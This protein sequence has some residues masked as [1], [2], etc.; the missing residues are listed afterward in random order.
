MCNAKG[1]PQTTQN[2][3]SNTFTQGQNSGTST[4]TSN[5]V[6][7]NTSNVGPNPE[8][9]ALYQQL[10]GNASGLAQTP[11]NPY[12]GQQVAPFTQA[13][14]DAGNSLWST[15]LGGMQFVPQASSL[16]GQAGQSTI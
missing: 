4:G 3:S 14:I 11:W 5:Q 6:G 9:L 16:I 13:Q 15:G 2:A 7:F 1:N 12:T 10:L 8:T